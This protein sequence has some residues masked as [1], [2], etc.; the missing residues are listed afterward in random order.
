[1]FAVTVAALGDNRQPDRAFGIAQSVQGVMLFL[2]F[3]SSPYLIKTWGVSGIFYMLA[4]VCILMMLSLFRFPSRGV[5]HSTLIA[6]HVEH[7][8]SSALL[9]WLGL[10]GSVIY[11]INVFGFWAFIERIG[12]AAGLP[13]RTIGLALGS[14]QIIAVGGAIA[15][16]LA[17]DRFG[18]TLPLLVVLAGQALVLWLLLGQFTSTT[19]F[20]GVGVFQALFMM[21]VCY[22]MGA[23]AKIDLNGRY[24]V[25]MTAAQ[26]L[27]AAFGPSIAAAAIG[28]GQDYSGIHLVS[29]LTLL[30]GILIFLVIVHYSRNLVGRPVATAG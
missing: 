1:M 29:G 3:S 21:A 28:E 6:Q 11:F 14:A 30:A 19:F 25:L 8:S 26:G 7:S 12:D 15:A 22:Q 2:A 4:G 24:L 18:R 20:I 9:I 10:I 17:S 23:I 5:D 27:G 13:G 16:A